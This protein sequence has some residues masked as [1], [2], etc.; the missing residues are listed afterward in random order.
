MR[1]ARSRRPL[2]GIVPV[3]PAAPTTR[4]GRRLEAASRAVAQVYHTCQGSPLRFDERAPA[5]IPNHLRALDIA[6]TRKSN[7]NWELGTR[8]RP[9]QTL[10]QVG[11]G[12]SRED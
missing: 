12:H 10:E 9:R 1:N 5:T 7:P 11:G 8:F 4:V 3:S 6:S 2:G